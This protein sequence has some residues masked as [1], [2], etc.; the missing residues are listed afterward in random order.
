MPF[1]FK[2][3]LLLSLPIFFLL[4]CKNDPKTEAAQ[5]APKIDTVRVDPVPTEGAAT[6]KVTEGI[7]EWSGTKTMKKTGHQGTITVESGEMLVNQGQLLSGKVTLDMNSI[8]VT[9]IKDPGERRDLESHL[10]DADFFEVNKFPKAEFVFT[11]VLPSTMPNFNWVLSGSLT[12]KG[13]TAPVNIPVKV[14]IEGDM[15]RAETPA[16]PINRTQWDVNF[17][18]GMLGT[19]KDK[20]IDDTVPLSLKIV[21]KK[22][23]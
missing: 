22:K 18:S 10:K 14:S 11:E 5:A 6:F 7:V 13:K 9:D 8:S 15:L 21:A 4:C 16:F 23:E 1:L 17:R 12:M 19:V 3:T 2:K 20:M